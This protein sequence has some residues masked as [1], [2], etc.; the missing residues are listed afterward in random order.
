MRTKK[1]V[2]AL[3]LVPVV[4][5]G[6]WRLVLVVSMEGIRSFDSDL[7]QEISSSI[8]GSIGDR[9]TV[10]PMIHALRDT[11][12]VNFIDDNLL[13]L[14][15]RYDLNRAPYITEPVGI[16]LNEETKHYNRV[17]LIYVL[18]QITGESFGYPMIG[19]D[20]VPEDMKPEIERGLSSVRSWWADRKEADNVDVKQ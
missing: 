4:V 16:I 3:L 11:Y 5:F 6:L 9:T 20:K 10:I 13:R 18:E 14:H 12:E 1:I 2:I 19:L 7:T 8:I 17:Q 15:R